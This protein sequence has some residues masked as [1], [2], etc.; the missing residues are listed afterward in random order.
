VERIPVSDQLRLFLTDQ[1]AARA[2]DEQNFDE[3]AFILRLTSVLEAPADLAGLELETVD[4]GL[5]QIAGSLDWALDT[6]RVP[7]AEKLACIERLPRLLDEIVTS[8]F[9]RAT[10]VGYFW[11]GFVSAKSPEVRQRILEAMRHGAESSPEEAVD[12]AIQGAEAFRAGPSIDAAAVVA[13]AAADRIDLPTSLREYAQ[14]LAFELE[15][16]AERWPDRR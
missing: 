14:R 9:G 2:K 8:G 11:E 1:A 6:S 12:S 15:R 7:L 16:E 10:A 5:W 3:R 13:N 4:A